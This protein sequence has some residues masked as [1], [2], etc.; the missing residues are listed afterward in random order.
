MSKEQIKHKEVIICLLFV[1]LVNPRNTEDSSALCE[2]DILLT[3]TPRTVAHF[4]NA[5]QGHFNGKQGR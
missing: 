1:Y 3:F 4:I 2:V 5:L